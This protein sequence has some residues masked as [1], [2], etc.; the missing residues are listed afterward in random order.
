MQASSH[1]EVIH[2]DP[3]RV[4]IHSVKTGILYK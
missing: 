1:S 3:P 2:S 4:Y